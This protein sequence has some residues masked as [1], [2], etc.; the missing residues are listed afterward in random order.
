MSSRFSEVNVHEDVDL[1]VR[2]LARKHPT[3]LFR[4]S[5]IAPELTFSEEDVLQALFLQC[6]RGLLEA[7]TKW[8]CVECDSTALGRIYESNPISTCHECGIDQEFV[9]ILYFHPTAYLKDKLAEEAAYPKKDD[10]AP[11]EAIERIAARQSDPPQQV[12]IKPPGSISELIAAVKD[13][14]AG[15][16]EVRDEAM[17]G[18]DAGERGAAESARG[19]TA[20]LETAQNTAAIRADDSPSEGVRWT[21][22]TYWL[23]LAGI[24]LAA[25]V[26]LFIWWAQETHLLPKLLHNEPVPTPSHSAQPGPSGAPKATPSPTPAASKPPSAAPRRA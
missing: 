1:L 17:H 24:V 19:A 11:D 2:G 18:A 20:A 13:V 23:T 3:L 10:A 6:K 7:V 14:R 25:A 16:R 21:R 4:A 26:A 22:R 8:R 9:P 5:S 15:V 12:D